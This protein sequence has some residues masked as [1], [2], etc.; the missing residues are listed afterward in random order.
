MSSSE[1][2]SG[3]GGRHDECARTVFVDGRPLLRISIEEAVF[4]PQFVLSIAAILT[5]SLD[6][7]DNMLFAD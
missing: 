3:S 7:L 2:P 1:V 5:V 4:D 6:D